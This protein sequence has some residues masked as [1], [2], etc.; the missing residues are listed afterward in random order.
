MMT[1]CN[2]Y[3]SNKCRQ[4]NCYS[5]EYTGKYFTASSQVITNT[6][7]RCNVDGYD[8]DDGG[9]DGD[10]T[11]DSLPV[12][13]QSLKR[14]CDDVTRSKMSVNS[15]KMEVARPVIVVTSTGSDTS[16]HRIQ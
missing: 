11:T 2:L 1:T 12:L 10:G 13:S 3:D 7:K 14:R 15:W 16:L 6:R 4:V 8:D 9:G 5:T